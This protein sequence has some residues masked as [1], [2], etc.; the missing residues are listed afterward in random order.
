MSDRPLRARLD[1]AAF[2]QLVAGEVVVL[3]TNTGQA[4]ELILA[5][6]GYTRLLRAVVDVKRPAAAGGGDG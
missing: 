5:D 3:E 6:I 1:E 2:R 4:L